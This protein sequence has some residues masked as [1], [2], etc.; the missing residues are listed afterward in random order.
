MRHREF[1]M[2]FWL[3][4]LSSLGVSIPTLPEPITKWVEPKTTPSKWWDA[5]HKKH[6]K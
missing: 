1:I 6:R 3:F 2:S 5:P 4:V